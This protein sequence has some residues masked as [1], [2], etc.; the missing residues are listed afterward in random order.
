MGKVSL[1]ASV[2]V[3]LAVPFAEAQPPTPPP[4]SVPVPALPTLP[5]PAVQ[6]DGAVPPLLP[7]PAPL[8]GMPGSG[9]PAQIVVPPA[10]PGPYLVP[11]ALPRRTYLVDAD[12]GGRLWFDADFLLWFVKNGPLKVPLVTTGNPNDPNPGA[13]GQPHTVVLFG[14]SNLDYGAIPGGRLEIGYWFDPESRFGIEAGFFWLAQQDVR[15]SAFSDNGGSPLLSI[16]FFNAQTRQEDEI[17]VAYPGYYAGGV[18]VRSTSVLGGAN[19][20]GFFN[21]ARGC[22]FQADL[23]GGF[24]FLDLRETLDIQTPDLSIASS[25]NQN[26]TAY[27]TVD[28]FRTSNQFYGGRLGGRLGYQWDRLSVDLNASVSLG[29]TYQSINI[30]GF[31]SATVPSS[32]GPSYA[33]G[34]IFAQPS[35]SARYWAWDFTVV[36]EVGLKLGYRV[37]RNLQFTVGYDFLYWSSVVRPGAQVNRD[38][39]LSQ[40]SLLGSGSLTG[41]AQPVAPLTRT[42]FFANGLNIGLELR[43]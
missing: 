40:S 6:P 30:Y 18:I 21:V 34:G 17:P 12:E 14:D 37:W 29:S 7:A 38:I 36:P 10:P 27:N 28:D 41:P 13:L 1:V 19:V 2:L 43:W 25:S 3:V 33:P 4:N 9:A 42:D 15:Y 5:A 8:P 39:N 11:D 16:P 20:D 26:G 22:G 24:R 32:S 35:N 23:F 31:S